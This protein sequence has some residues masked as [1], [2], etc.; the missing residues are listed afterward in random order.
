MRLNPEMDA[1]IVGL[2]RAMRSDD[3]PEDHP[4]LYAAALIDRLLKM[5]EML[6]EDAPVYYGFNGQPYVL[7]N[8]VFYPGSDTELIP[9]ELFE[10][11]YQTWKDKGDNGLLCW[12]AKRRGIPPVDWRGRPIEDGK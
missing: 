8:D 1:Q 7:V 6:S 11:V 5:R 9:D 2:L 12:A 3:N 4:Y 10:E